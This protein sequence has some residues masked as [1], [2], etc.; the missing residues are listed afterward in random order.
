MRYIRKRSRSI[1]KLRKS[2]KKRSRKVRKISKHSRKRSV[3]KSS[4]KRRR[5]IIKNKDGGFTPE[6]A[7]KY[8]KNFIKNSKEYG[9][10]SVDWIIEDYK[11][12]PE[13]YKKY[14][15]GLLAIALGVLVVIGIKYINRDEDREKAQELAE[16]YINHL[17]YIKKIEKDNRKVLYLNEGANN[18]IFKVGNDKIIRIPKEY[19]DEN[20]K[21][22]K[23]AYNET[24]INNAKILSNNK[25]TPKLYEMLPELALYDYYDTDIADILKDININEDI[26]ESVIRT[27][28]NIIKKV[29]EINYYCSD[30]KYSN[31]IAKKRDKKTETIETTESKDDTYNQHYDIR[32]IDIDDCK[33]DNV[34]TVDM[35]HNDVKTQEETKKFYTILSIYQFCFLLEKELLMKLDI[36]SFISE[37]VDDKY[38]IEYII[39]REIYVE[40]TYN[41]YFDSLNYYTRYYTGNDFNIDTIV[42][43]IKK[44]SDST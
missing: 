8:L 18:Y 43:I 44:S 19:T 26:K 39:K 21:K 13:K 31:F 1:I 22:Q 11:I 38:D 23:G 37:I 5:K 33:I 36:S 12:N 32:M 29:Y 35:D 9:N 24:I 40:T 16:S 41:S 15:G 6:N 30:I 25:I 2:S 28:I 4:S 10:K 3:K 20:G 17:V 34:R 27:I 7:L 42:N 14:A